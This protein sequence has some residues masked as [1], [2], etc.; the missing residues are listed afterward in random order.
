MP[1]CPRHRTRPAADV[2]PAGSA[3]DAVRSAAPTA[4]FRRKSV[5]VGALVAVAAALASVP[6]AADS[7]A[8]FGKRRVAD[9]S[10]DYYV[11]LEGSFRSGTFV[12]ARRA[13]DSAPVTNAG[14]RGSDGDAVVRP[15]DTVL[16]RGELA[17]LPIRTLVSSNGE[18][19]ALIDRYGGTG[20]GDAVAVFSGDGKRRHAVTLA[21]LYD[22]ET[23]ETF[24]RSVS[25]VHWHSMS[26][27]DD[28]TESVLVYGPGGLRAVSTEA[29]TVRTGTHDDIRRGIGHADSNVAAAAVEI[30][31]RE[32]VPGL[33]PV[34]E[35]IVADVARPITLRLRAGALVGEG[36][37]A[38][39][40]LFR[41]AVTVPL[42]DDVDERDHRFAVERL[43]DVFGERA[44]P[45]LRAALK[46]KEGWGA[47]PPRL[48]A[49][50]RRR[51]ADVDRGPA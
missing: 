8:P 23:R 4:G 16:A 50:G 21:D 31:Q 32:S 48:R 15:G 9:P 1:A 2:P 38:A 11:V 17:Q 13:G 12:Y 41:H 39:Q 36:S 35:A 14:G 22:E 44:L 30:A 28:A 43:G 37:E 33:G 5:F 29:G 34:C 26:W 40:E 47:S 25:S 6:A 3:S 24:T 10:G 45:M 27:L 51:R 20:R 49:H 18:G 46:T 19:F 7:W 42:P